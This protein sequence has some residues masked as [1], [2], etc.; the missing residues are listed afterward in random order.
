MTDGLQ[1]PFQRTIGEGRWLRKFIPYETASAAGDPVAILEAHYQ[2]LQ[3]QQQANGTAPG[4]LSLEQMLAQEP[5]LAE[6]LELAET[7]YHE[8]QPMTPSAVFRENLR[9][10]LMTAHRQRTAQHTLFPYVAEDEETLTWSWQLL[11]TVPVL[12]GILAF[13][14]RRTHRSAEQPMEAGA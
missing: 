14:W 5:D 3:A 6:V 1:W 12:L 10:A 11:A 13:I 8:I 4:D 2:A 7:L 9:L